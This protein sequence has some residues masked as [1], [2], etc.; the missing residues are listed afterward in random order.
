[1]LCLYIHTFTLEPGKCRFPYKI[2][3]SNYHVNSIIR[4][5]AIHHLFAFFASLLIRDPQEKPY[6][7]LFDVFEV[8]VLD[9]LSTSSFHCIE[10]MLW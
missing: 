10:L 5:G 4:F 6:Y 7:H 8:L 1:M 9:E 2:M 3:P